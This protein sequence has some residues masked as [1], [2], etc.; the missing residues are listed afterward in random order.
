MSGNSKSLLFLLQRCVAVRQLTSSTGIKTKSSLLTGRIFQQRSLS[1]LSARAVCV[2]RLFELQSVVRNSRISFCSKTGESCE[3]DYPP[4]PAYQSEQ[5]GKDVYIVQVRGLP[6]SCSGQEILQFF[7]E[8][9]IRDGE[10]G[11]HITYDRMGRPTGRAFLEMEHE[12]DVRKALEKHRQYLGPRYI[13]VSEVTNRD[14]EE[15]LKNTVQTPANDGVVRLRGLPFSC[16][17]YDVE[18]FFSGLDIISNGITFVSNHRGRRSGEAYV[19]F[20]SQDAANEA[21]CR[22]KENMGHRYIEV[23]PSRRSEIHEVWG[24]KR[25]SVVPQSSPEMSSGSTMSATQDDPRAGP[26]QRSS[27]SLHYIHVR[28]LPFQVTVEEIIKF[29]SPFVISKIVIECAPGGLMNGEADVYFHCHQDAM[30][31]MCKNREYIGERYI[32]L[33]LNSDTGCDAR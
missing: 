23:F 5:E 22:H 30:A 8:C 3:D 6:W 17:E 7:S 14:A 20:S 27:L 24:R 31:A 2:Q 25:S 33:F 21:L 29:F 1:S 18:Q 19:Q 10:K 32:E 4:L 28:G 16:T 9:R 12:E 26:P 11:I 13:E 15:I